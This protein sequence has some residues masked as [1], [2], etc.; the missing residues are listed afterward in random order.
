MRNH[1]M[2]CRAWGVAAV[3]LSVLLGAGQLITAETI[4]ENTP[5]PPVGAPGGPDRELTPTELETWKRGRI[6]FDK[7]FK[8]PDGLG[9]PELNGDSCRGCHQD[10]VIG[11]SGGLDV[12]VF[13]FGF[14]NNGLG[15]FQDLP[16]GQAA[17]KLR[18]QDVPGRE[19][20]DA[21][22]DVFELRQTPTALGI[23]RIGTIADATIIAN[24]DPIDLNSDGIF[25]VARFINVAGTM[26]V[27]KYGWKAQIPKVLDFAHDATAGE[28]GITT[29]DNG[30]RFWPLD[31][32]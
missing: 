24:E 29:E 18:R 28:L 17:S 7:D 10:P 9:T 5:V 31:R 26:E 20:H 12:N 27:G 23:G 6:L 16:G 8:L 19:N 11:G 21:M 30:P 2:K 3:V 4:D 15:P 32:Q 14:D 1:N 13:R 25:G 22:A